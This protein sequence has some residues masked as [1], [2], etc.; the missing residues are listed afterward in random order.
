MYLLGHPDCYKS[1][2]FVPLYWQSFVMKVCK[3]FEDEKPLDR[4]QKVTL[5]EKR[6]RV[7]GLSPV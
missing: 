3:A 1:H 5:I 7:I 4:A 6:G 2:G